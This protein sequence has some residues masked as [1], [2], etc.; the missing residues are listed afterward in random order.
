[1]LVTRDSVMLVTHDSAMLVTHDSVMLVT[2]DSVYMETRRPY[3]LSNITKTQI[4]DQLKNH[5]IL[6]LQLT[7]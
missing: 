3:L 2:R 1:M 7:I 4:T 6:I 5:V